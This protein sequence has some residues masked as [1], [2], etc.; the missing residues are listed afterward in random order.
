MKIL[1]YTNILRF[2]KELKWLYCQTQFFVGL[3]SLLPLG[4]WLFDSCPAVLSLLLLIL[5]LYSSI[6][7]KHSIH[8]TKNSMLIK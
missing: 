3:T 5:S 6:R 4:V 7:Q 1:D 2:L 8:V